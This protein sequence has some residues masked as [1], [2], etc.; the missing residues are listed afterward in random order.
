MLLDR[1]D[2]ALALR[3]PDAAARAFDA[4][5]EITRQAVRSALLAERSQDPEVNRDP[6]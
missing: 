2:D 4:I 1:L 3:D 6:Q 5:Y